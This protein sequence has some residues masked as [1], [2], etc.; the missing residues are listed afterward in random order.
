MTKFLL[1]A[2]LH[3]GFGI[4]TNNIIW[5]CL[6]RAKKN[7]VDCVIVAG[8]LISHDQN[9]WE[10]ILKMLRDEFPSIPILFVMGNHDF[11]SD[12]T[13]TFLQIEVRRQQLF[14]KYN[15]HNLEE[16]DYKINNINIMG[17]GGWY[18]LDFPPSNDCN[19]IHKTIE[20]I[21]FNDYLFAK[22]RKSV[23]RI[24]NS[25]KKSKKTIVVSHFLTN[26]ESMG[27]LSEFKDRII[28]ANNGKLMLVYGHIH[29]E[30]IE[31]KKDYD[32][33]VIGADY[34]K[35]QYLIVDF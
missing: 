9:Q 27:T 18:W 23:D 31:H 21:P 11:W 22:A 32:M 6:Q 25:I 29:R 14:K 26:D 10:P 34:N 24:V 1:L 28:D 2:D 3:S 20:G 17:Y 8:D 5:M 15:I 33:Y 13:Q 7:N 30:I 16:C 19:F 12:R 35:P 4:N